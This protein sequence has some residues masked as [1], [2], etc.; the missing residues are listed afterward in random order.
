MA[1]E[2]S[3]KRAKATTKKDE[4]PK[5]WIASVFSSLFTSRRSHWKDQIKAIQDDTCE[6]DFHLDGVDLGVTDARVFAEALESNSSI[7]SLTLC[8]NN[9]TAVEAATIANAIAYNS[10]LK[11]LS[12][13]RNNIGKDGATA[14]G[15]ALGC[16]ATLVGL[17][18]IS[19]NI[20]DAGVK[21]LAEGMQLN[22]T[23]Q[24]LHL[25]DN[26]I[27][28]AG[29]KAL[30]EAM[31]E[32]NTLNL[33]ELSDNP[34]STQS[35]QSGGSTNSNTSKGSES[36]PGDETRLGN[37]SPTLFDANTVDNVVASDDSTFQSIVSQYS[38]HQSF[39]RWLARIGLLEK[40]AS[41][42]DE[43]GV[44]SLE[45]LLIGID[46]GIIKIDVLTT[47]GLKPIHAAR[48]IRKAQQAVQRQ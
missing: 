2:P 29:A 43:F 38:F 46:E 44:E 17:S 37:N 27:G 34:I 28:D 24:E 6:S 31:T 48:L 9:M 7:E 4:K 12:I 16:N 36:A 14:F 23:L 1:D 45:D 26:K 15:I 30:H 3:A 32:N 40:C 8:K 47:K 21:A 35:K 25:N 39:T 41:V 13:I 18:L 5:S 22:R 19:N 33:L 10:T 42:L 20:G 11:Y